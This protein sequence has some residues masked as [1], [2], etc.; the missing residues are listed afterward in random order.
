MRRAW[1]VG[2]GVLI[3]AAGVAAWRYC[4]R[5][6]ESPPP[7][8]SRPIWFEDVTDRVG[9]NFTH[10][11]GPTG[12]Y[13]MPQVIGSGCAIIDFDGDGRPD[14]YLMH[15]VPPGSASTNKL[16]RNRPDGTFEDVSAGS[17][18]DFAAPCMGAAVGDVNNDGK[19]DLLVTLAGGIKLFL[20]L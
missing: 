20:N 15:N 7:E 11:C 12:R 18:L 5:G 1:W 16:F 8:P 14:L 3:V 10:D 13:P 6:P 2:I 17:G 9:L 19:P 4:L